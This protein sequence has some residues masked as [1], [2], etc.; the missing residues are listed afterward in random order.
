MT[1]SVDWALN[2]NYL[3]IYL[4]RRAPAT[5]DTAAALLSAQAMLESDSARSNYTRLVV[6]LTDGKKLYTKVENVVSDRLLV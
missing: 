4:Y 5:T 1:F 6:L 3:S 2:N